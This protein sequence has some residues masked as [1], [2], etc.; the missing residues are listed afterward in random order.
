MV[1]S[2]EAYLFCNNYKLYTKTTTIYKN[3]FFKCKKA[4]LKLFKQHLIDSKGLLLKMFTFKLVRQD[5]RRII[6]EVSSRDVYSLAQDLIGFG[7]KRIR[8][9]SIA[10]LSENSPVYSRI[11]HSIPRNNNC[12]HNSILR[13]RTQH[14]KHTHARRH[15]RLQKPFLVLVPVACLR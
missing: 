2:L 8:I 4:A 12:E 5:I 9:N 15:A 10:L 11:V 3:W 14:Q 7:D 1:F 6:C 13:H